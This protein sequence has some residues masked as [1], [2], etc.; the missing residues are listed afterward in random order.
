MLTI[1]LESLKGFS[2]NNTS[3]R[4]GVGPSSRF[5][6]QAKAVLG[7]YVST[8]LKP[9]SGSYAAVQPSE[10][11]LK[12][13]NKKNPVLKTLQ[14]IFT[15]KRTNE[16]SSSKGLAADLLQTSVLRLIHRGSTLRVEELARLANQLLEAEHTD[17]Y[18]SPQSLA[19]QKQLKQY[20]HKAAPSALKWL[21]NSVDAIHAVQHTIRQQMALLKQQTEAQGLDWSV[22][23]A[24]QDTRD[25][26][27]RTVQADCTLHPNVLSAV[28]E[29]EFNAPPQRFVTPNGTELHISRAYLESKG[30]AW[31]EH[32]LP[33]LISN[34]ELQMKD[35]VQQLFNACQKQGMDWDDVIQTQNLNARLMTTF[36]K[37]T[38]SPLGAECPE[39]VQQLCHHALTAPEHYRIFYATRDKRTVELQGPDLKNLGKVWRTQTFLTEAT[40]LEKEVLSFVAN[41]SKKSFECS[42]KPI[43]PEEMRIIVSHHF[44][45]ENA[46]AKAYPKLLETILETVFAKKEKVE[47]GRFFYRAGGGGYPANFK[48]GYMKKGEYFQ[49]TRVKAASGQVYELLNTLTEADTKALFREHGIKK[50]GK[51]VLGKGS[52]GKVRLARDI[53][54]GKLVAVKKFQ[55]NE[56][57]PLDQQSS[58]TP[59]QEAKTEITQFQKVG[60][61][62]QPGSSGHQTLTKMRDYAHVGI[63]SSQPHTNAP[64]QFRHQGMSSSFRKGLVGKSYIFMDLANQ[65][66]GKAAIAELNNIRLQKT[67]QEAQLACINL[68]IQYAKAVSSMHELQLT[69]RDIKPAN[70]L[71]MKDPKTGISQAKLAD[72]G[73]VSDQGRNKVFAGRTPRYT[74]PEANNGRER[75]EYSAPA[76]DAFSLGL[77]LF[78]LRNAALGDS[79]LDIQLEGGRQGKTGVTMNSVIQNGINIGKKP[80]KKDHLDNLI[81]KLLSHDKATR[82][83]PREAYQELLYIKLNYLGI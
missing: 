19:E 47:A 35:E 11:L 55:P 70:F 67:P 53:A 62:L 7:H 83:T 15:G 3:G 69:H 24:A 54:T 59:E 74:P 52:Y 21:K 13:L 78:E 23:R 37:S 12:T 77:V 66:D 2:P 26:V 57:R 30:N 18:P 17:L 42:E 82:S 20:I 25:A 80:L 1:R 72:F 44:Q 6:Q 14:R 27:A 43:H 73:F 45:A 9:Q 61:R 22:V 75:S 49:N 48:G 32:T 36:S 16:A 40:R 60:Q 29:T 63:A 34:L 64:S 38:R 41:Q 39:I 81:A 10:R 31:V 79:V 46:L 76:H 4:A 33:M 50:T 71:H 5:A 58:K 28:L 65:G 68:A 8:C 51:T 56:Q